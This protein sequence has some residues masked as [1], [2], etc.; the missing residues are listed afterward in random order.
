LLPAPAVVRLWKLDVDG[1]ELDVLKSFQSALHDGRVDVIQMELI[2]E[3]VIELSNMP[4]SKVLKYLEQLGYLLYVQV[5]PDRVAGSRDDAGKHCGD[6]AE[7]LD[8]LNLVDV[9]EP[10]VHIPVIQDGQSAVI[11]A[12]E[13]SRYT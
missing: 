8:M 12:S 10:W 3:E 6:V 5:I 4:K 2:Q 11:P 1:V 13:S 9:S 7:W